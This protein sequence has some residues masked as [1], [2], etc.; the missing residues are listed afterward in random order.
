MKLRG[1]GRIY[2][3][4]TRWWI[5]YWHCGRQYREPAA[6]PGTIEENTEKQAQTKLNNRLAEKRTGTFV[7]PAAERLT[8]GEL[9]DALEAD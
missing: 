8:V 1:D 3:R 4:G 7:G 2:Q 9:L 6:T 5:E